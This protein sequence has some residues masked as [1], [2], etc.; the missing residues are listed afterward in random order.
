MLT[1]LEEI[2]NIKW[3][4]HKLI[5]L[6]IIR[7]ITHQKLALQAHEPK[8]NSLHM[9]QLKSAVLRKY[10]TTC[11]S[12]NWLWVFRFRSENDANLLA[13]RIALLR[14]EELRTRKK[15]EETMKRTDEI[16]SLKHRNLER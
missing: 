3:L 10:F 14:Q 12:E 9:M 15:I 16:N 11:V 5:T 6:K 8:S 13:N 2:I 7:E 4:T 1:L